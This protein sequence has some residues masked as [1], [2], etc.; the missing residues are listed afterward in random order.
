VI[1]VFRHDALGK[2]QQSHGSFLCSESSKALRCQAKEAMRMA[3]L[4]N[5]GRAYL[6]P[7]LRQYCV[8]PESDG[9]GIVATD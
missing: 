8:L 3:E 4:A 5:R 7:I 2:R 6:R 1:G 9:C